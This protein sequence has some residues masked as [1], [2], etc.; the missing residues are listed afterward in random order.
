MDFTEG[1]RYEIAANMTV[2]YVQLFQCQPR[3]L[4][5]LLKCQDQ[6]DQI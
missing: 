2:I 4:I 3:F 5:V 6:S 1:H